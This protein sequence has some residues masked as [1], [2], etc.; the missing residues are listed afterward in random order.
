MAIDCGANMISLTCTAKREVQ[1]SDIGIAGHWWSQNTNP[2]VDASLL[3]ILLESS[4]VSST[5]EN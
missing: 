5:K 2:G 1:I 3:L 4:W